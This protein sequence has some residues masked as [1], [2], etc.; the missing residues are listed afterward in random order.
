MAEDVDR[1]SVCGTANPSIAYFGEL[2][3]QRKLAPTYPIDTTWIGI[4]HK[5]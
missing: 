3:A 1:Y 5:I 4:P 2:S